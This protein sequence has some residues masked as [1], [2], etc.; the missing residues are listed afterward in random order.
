MDAELEQNVNKGPESN[1]IG[2]SYNRLF[3]LFE[4]VIIR[5]GRNRLKNWSG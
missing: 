4:S 1:Y 2:N 3:P 5:G